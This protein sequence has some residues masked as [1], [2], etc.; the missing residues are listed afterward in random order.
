MMVG[1]SSVLHCQF[2]NSFRLFRHMLGRQHANIGTNSQNFFVWNGVAVESSAIKENEISCLAVNLDTLIKWFF[3]FIFLWYFIPIL[4]NLFH[5]FLSKIFLMIVVGTRNTH[6][7]TFILARV[8]QS[9]N[10]LITPDISMDRS[11]IAMQERIY[12]SGFIVSNS[13][14]EAKSIEGAFDLLSFP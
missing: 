13:I 6:K 12:L 1:H 7:S 3:Y 4:F 9:L 2:S 11:L 8:C 14:H 5:T 10:S